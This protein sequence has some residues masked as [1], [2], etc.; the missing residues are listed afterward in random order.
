MRAAHRRLHVVMWAL[1]AAATAWAIVLAIG[2]RPV[3]PQ[4]E[5]PED[6]A[7]ETP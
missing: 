6:I 4:T 3:D 7:G 1:V 2:A 5:L